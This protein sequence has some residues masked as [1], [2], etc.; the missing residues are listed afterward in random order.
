M[1][2]ITSTFSLF[3][4]HFSNLD[5][6]PSPK[7]SAERIK[8]CVPVKSEEIKC[9]CV[10]NDNDNSKSYIPF[11]VEITDSNEFNIYKSSNLPL[12]EDYIIE[13]IRSL[14][15]IFYFDIK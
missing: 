8:I 7:T 4:S 15:K 5:G 3:A 14:L 13:K 12:P 6:S 1:T 11:I 9:Y 10:K 2:F